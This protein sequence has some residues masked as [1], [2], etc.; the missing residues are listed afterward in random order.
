MFA[1]PPDTGI[2]RHAAAPRATRA[3]VVALAPHRERRAV[4]VPA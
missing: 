2:S 3:P 1:T 4:A